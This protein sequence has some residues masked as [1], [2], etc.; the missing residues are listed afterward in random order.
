MITKGWKVALS[1]FLLFWFHPSRA[2]CGGASLACQQS[3]RIDG[4]AKTGTTDSNCLLNCA[5][6]RTSCENAAASGAL[7]QP[8]ADIPSP[9]ERV[10]LKQHDFV[11]SRSRDNQTAE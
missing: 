2:D 9:G 7:Q 11:P 6:G 4:Q 3:C 5:L 1:V 10:P 8:T